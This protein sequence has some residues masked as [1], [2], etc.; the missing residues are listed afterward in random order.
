MEDNDISFGHEA[1]FITG[2]NKTIW[3]LIILP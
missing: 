2:D 1:E 3:L